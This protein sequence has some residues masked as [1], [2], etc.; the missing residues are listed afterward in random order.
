M[1]I[2]TLTINDLSE[3]FSREEVEEFLNSLPPNEVLALKYKWEFWARPNQ[4]APAGN[5][6]YWMPLAGR[7]FGKTRLGAE[8]VRSV[9]EKGEVEF[10]NIIGSTNG[11]VRGTMIEGE[12]GILRVSPPWFKPTYLPSKK[13]VEWPNGV[14]A[15]LFSAE[16][17][18]RLRG[19]QCGAFWADEIAAW[20]NNLEETWS[21]LMFGFRLGRNP[22]GVATTTPRPLPLIKKL[23]ANKACH[24]TT[25]TT[26]ENSANLAKPFFD[27]VITSYEGTRLGRQELLG[28]VLD[29]NPNALFRQEWFDRN[30]LEYAPTD[31]EKVVVA[32]DPQV[33]E[34]IKS[35]EAGIVTG[36]KKTIDGIEHY[37]VLADDSFQPEKPKDWGKAAA[38]AYY[39]HQANEVVAEVNNGGALVKDNI[40]SVDS[41][42]P[43]AMVSATRGKS[44]R[45]EP[46]ATLME[47]GR[48][49]FCGKFEKLETQCIEWDPTMTKQKSPDRMDA[50]VWLIS[51]LSGMV[52]RGMS[53]GRAAGK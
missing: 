17:P 48:V 2:S 22:Q 4:L 40:Q 23:M 14:K 31:L 32:V 43:V 27:E 47:Q 45:A 51:R 12:S 44:I 46:V 52:G 24:V 11:D 3:M 33:K 38:K 50:F 25:G 13:M 34:D 30:R 18:D 8:W 21:N 15:Q 1:D 29:D 20:G 42:I 10:I 16:E 7:G 19:P 28:H 26:Y 9:A 6:T 36:G 5:W 53:Q 49:H 35:D 41:S 39:T 37:Y